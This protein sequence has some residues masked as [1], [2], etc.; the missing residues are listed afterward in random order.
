MTM[1][2]ADSTR[3]AA[4]SAS[5]VAVTGLPLARATRSLIDFSSVSLW[6]DTAVQ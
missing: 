2:L 5:E 1:R 4:T 3:S 6:G